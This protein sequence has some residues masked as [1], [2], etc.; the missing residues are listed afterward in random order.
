MTKAKRNILGSIDVS[1]RR[2]RRKNLLLL[3][4]C[5]QKICDAE[6]RYLYNIPA[7]LQ[8]GEMYG[9]TED[10]IYSLYDVMDG[11]LQVYDY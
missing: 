8:G 9:I 2:N 4:E 6:E 7:N 3:T 1:T 11:L 10:I 5:V